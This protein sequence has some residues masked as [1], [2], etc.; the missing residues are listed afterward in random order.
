MTF[1]SLQ[2]TSGPTWS[3]NTPAVGAGGTVTCTNASVAAGSNSTFVLTGH[4]PTA[5]PSGTVYT[6]TASVSSS[7]D[8]NPENNSAEASTS[9]VSAAPTL[10]TQ[11]SSPVLLGGSISDTATLS[12][13]SS[14]TGPIG[15][16]AFG[17]NGSTCSQTPAFTSSADVSG[18]GQYNSGPFIPS[19][20]GTY[21]FV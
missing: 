14:A 19:A 5:E 12:G 20:P 6:N 13:G 1:V 11:A 16:F 3:C 7:N 15:F 2:Q 18:D 4:I 17:P 9:V 21:R 10:T 8:P